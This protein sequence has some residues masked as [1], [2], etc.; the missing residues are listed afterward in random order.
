MSDA[1]LNLLDQLSLE[2]LAEAVLLQALDD[3]HSE[4]EDL[5]NG[6]QRWF[7]GESGA[8][9]TF[10]LCCRILHERPASM[11]EKLQIPC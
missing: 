2:K 1:A 10:E 7:V 4:R 9:F 3:Y 6:A 11:L 5:R 8:G